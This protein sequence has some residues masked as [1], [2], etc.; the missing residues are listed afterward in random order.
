M[1]AIT[2]SV[3][4]GAAG[5]GQITISQ[6]VRNQAKLVFE[7]ADRARDAAVSQVNY[8]TYAES[9]GYAL[10]VYERDNDLPNM[11]LCKSRIAMLLSAYQWED[12]D[13][14][15][16]LAAE[17]FE[18]AVKILEQ[19]GDMRSAAVEAT[20]SAVCRLMKHA[21]TRDDLEK[22]RVRLAFSMRHKMEYS[23]DWAY[24]KFNLGLLWSMLPA[25][26][27]AREQQLVKAKNNI[28]GSLR[29]FGD[30]QSEHFGP[31]LVEIARIEDRLIDARSATLLAEAVRTH[32]D[33]LPVRVQQNAHENPVAIGSILV[34]NP[35]TLG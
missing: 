31:A 20:N 2:Q 17:L 8:S 28:Y 3:R 18:E 10:A 13:L 19:L 21:P 1:D 12:V 15:K 4:R 24:T 22:A 25:T 35:E 14:T 11:A 16:D 26:G 6:A 33:E 9:Y 32:I 7:E 5:L 34:D 29:I 23:E 30:T 27:L